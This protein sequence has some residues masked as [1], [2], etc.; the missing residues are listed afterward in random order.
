MSLPAA[1]VSKALVN[2]TQR[3][4]HD[5]HAH[6]ELGWQEFR[7][8][9]LVADRLRALGLDDV[10]TGV[11]ETGVVGLLRGGKPGRTVALRADM[12]ALPIQEETGLKFASKTPGVMHACGHDGHVA[13]LLGAAELLAGMRQDIVGNV[14]FIFQPAEEGGA[15]GKFM[16]EAGC[17]RDPDVDAIFAFHC[18]RRLKVGHIEL[19]GHP[20]AGVRSFSMTVTGRGGH[21]AY[22]H[23][24]VDPVAAACQI[25]TAA[26]TI[27]SREIHPGQPA[28]VSFCSIHAG[29]K[30]N[31]I[32]DSVEICGT[33]R[34]TDMK[35]LDQIWRA[36][37]RVVRNV[38]RAMRVK[39][40]IEPAIV[41]PP[42]Q[43]D[44]GMTQLVRSVGAELLGKR[45]VHEM[46][47]QA[48][49]AED[50]AFYMADQGGVPGVMFR[51][52]VESSENGHTSRFDFG[53][54]AVE[55]AILMMANVALKALALAD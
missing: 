12:D 7:T 38:A 6:P 23:S 45:K 10:R 21:G 29:T 46:T 34:A 24:C 43:C 11:A 50:F 20:Y 19:S 25:V 4:R 54:E 26:Q 47:E 53:E 39:V 16:V 5:I 48:M 27:V 52:G 3:I 22:P 32:P 1:R 42:L 2:R 51:L 35:T 28:V 33:T 37:G 15:G 13:V 31:I 55:P 40:Q 9:G 41:Y 30:N 14:K 49:G 44:P 8:A 17:L 36:F 18:A